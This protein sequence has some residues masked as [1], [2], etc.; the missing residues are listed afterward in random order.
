MLEARNPRMDL[1]ACPL[2]LQKD[3]K[4]SNLNFASNIK[5]I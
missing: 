4:G 5:W 1:F 2:D 3:S